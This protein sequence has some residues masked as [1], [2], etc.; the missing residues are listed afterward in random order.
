MGLRGDRE[1]V[2]GIR[3]GTYVN[4]VNLVQIGI[5]GRREC[6]MSRRN[7]NDVSLP[8]IGIHGWGVYNVSEK[9]SRVLIFWRWGYV[10]GSA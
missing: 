6:I 10:K 3:E 1:C 8:E 2:N 9:M 5:H 7:V 4:D